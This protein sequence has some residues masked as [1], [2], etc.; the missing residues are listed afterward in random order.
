MG[1]H[2]TPRVNRFP[3]VT[4]VR[5]S[6]GRSTPVPAALP[7]LPGWTGLTSPGSPQGSFCLLRLFVCMRGPLFATDIDQRGQSYHSW[8]SRG[9]SLRNNCRNTLNTHGIL[10]YGLSFLRRQVTSY[11]RKRFLLSVCLAFTTA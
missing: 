7:L 10:V 11:W 2:L 1:T 4:K 3:G 6:S 9:I 5:F 8:E